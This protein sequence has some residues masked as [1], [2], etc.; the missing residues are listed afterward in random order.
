MDPADEIGFG[1]DI[2][3]AVNY[4]T[5]TNAVCLSGKLKGNFPLLLYTIES[6][7]YFCAF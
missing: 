4:T 2:M 5:M 7:C 6:V 3:N 1:D